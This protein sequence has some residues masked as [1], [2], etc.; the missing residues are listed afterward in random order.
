[1]PAEERKSLQP[2]DEKRLLWLTILVAAVLM[3]VLAAISLALWPREADGRLWWNPQGSNIFIMWV[4][5]AILEW[6]LAGAMVAH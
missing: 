6:A 2:A 5:I 1:M 3:L 4:P